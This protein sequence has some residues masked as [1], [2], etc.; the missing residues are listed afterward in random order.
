MKYKKD[1]TAVPNTNPGLCGS[2]RLIIM[3]YGVTSHQTAAVSQDAGIVV[4]VD[5]VSGERAA[6]DGRNPVTLVFV[7]CVAGQ[8]GGVAPEDTRTTIASTRAV[9]NQVALT[10]KLNT[11]PPVRERSHI[12]D[13]MISTVYTVGFINTT[14]AEPPNCAVA[15]L[16]VSTSVHVDAVACPWTG[17]DETIAFQVN[18]YVIDFDGDAML[19]RG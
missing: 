10:T 2:V 6:P 12:D 15:D 9:L 8:R 14:S 5:S 7:D 16:H 4:V 17:A 13:T 1:K 3:A 19:V 11:E 18:G